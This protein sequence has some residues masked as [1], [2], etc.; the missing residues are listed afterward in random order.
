MFKIE[1]AMILSF[2]HRCI[3]KKPSILKQLSGPLALVFML[4]PCVNGGAVGEKKTVTLSRHET[5]AEF[6]GTSEHR[7][8]G[9]TSF[10][11]DK[12]GHSG[13]LATFRIVNYLSYDKPGEYGDPKSDEFM[14]LLEDNRKQPKVPA[15][16]LAAVNSLKQGDKVLLSWNHDYVTVDGSSRPQRPLTKLEKI[17]DIGSKEWLQ[18]IDRLVGVRDASGHG[19][20]IAS[21][22]W[23]QAVSV[24]LKVYDD[25]GHGPPPDSDE[26]RSAIHRNAFGSH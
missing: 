3:V 26:W 20:A 13:S 23:V 8:R 14:F 9:L 4:S 10:C 22:E 16:I 1:T 6:R 5:V 19:P 24:K 7:C 21:D 17:A 2:H 15:D 25:Q 18:Q 11:P 12:C